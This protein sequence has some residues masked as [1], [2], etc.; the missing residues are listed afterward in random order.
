MESARVT[1]CLKPEDLQNFTKFVAGTRV[2][3]AQ[4]AGMI[5]AAMSVWAMLQRGPDFQTNVFRIFF[6]API[7][8]VGIWII[9]SY[10][11][12]LKSIKHYTLTDPN[13]FDARSFEVREDGF[14]SEDTNGQSL[15]RWT[16]IRRFA[17]TEDAIY[18]F[19][20]PVRGF[21]IPKRC[22][23]GATEAAIFSNQV[24]LHLKG[25]RASVAAK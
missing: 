21:I 16:S 17:E 24:L 10:G 5:V 22:F 3:V 12:S 7:G 1:V 19:Q 4:A 25:D 8:I 23:A 6:V 2:R 18:L 11:R 13:V 14:F 20:S 15:A 9:F